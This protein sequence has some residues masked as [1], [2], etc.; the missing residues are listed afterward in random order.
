MVGFIFNLNRDPFKDPRVRQAFNLAFP[1]EEIEQGAV[2]RPV[3]ADQ[4]L[5]LRHP[6]RRRRA[7]R[8]GASWRSSRRSRTRC[9]RRS[10]PPLQEP[11]Q[12]HADQGAQQPS[13]GA[14]AAR[15][16]PAGKLKDNQLI[17]AATGKPMAVEFLLE[18]RRLYEKIALPYQQRARPRSASTSR[19]APV[20]TA[21]Y[22][23][24]VRSRDFD[25][26]Y[27]GW[28]Q[29]M[30]PGNEQIDFFGSQSADREGSRNYGGDQAIR[31]STR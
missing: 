14:E 11:G 16:R 29:S 1:F 15:A 2:L 13:C 28:A 21:Q 26:I 19:S 23:N 30:S 20:D 27:T 5:L 10:S 4:Q 18:R 31:R 17:G 7:S 22:E 6:A 8:R 24:R 25:I 3:Q 12:R 9:R